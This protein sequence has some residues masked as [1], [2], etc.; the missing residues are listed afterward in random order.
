M[1]MLPHPHIG[2]DIVT[3]LKSILAIFNITTRIICATTDSGSNVVLAIRLLNMHLSMQNHRFYSRH[4]LAHVLHL[5]VMAGMAPIK[6]SIE[7]VRRFVKAIT[8]SSTIAQDFKKIGQSVGEGEVVRKIPQN[9]STRW[10][11]TYLMLSVYTSMP[12]TIAAVMRRHSNLAYY[13]L[14]QE[15]DSD[16]QAVTR[17]LQPFYEITNILSGSTYVTLGLSALLMDDIIDVITSYIQDSSSS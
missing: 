8:S 6:V 17:F 5:V 14:T 16:L 10:N 4:C 9:I 15:E 7:K 12:T 2:E 1:C 3:Q 13:R 11:S